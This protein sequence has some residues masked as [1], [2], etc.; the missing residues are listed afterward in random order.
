MPPV[1]PYN[2]F[3]KF[4]SVFLVSTYREFKEKV[5]ACNRIIE[6]LT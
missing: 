1:I 2:P 4:A 3:Y 6:E 5:K